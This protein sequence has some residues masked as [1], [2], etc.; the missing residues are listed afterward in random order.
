MLNQEQKTILGK[1]GYYISFLVRAL[2]PRSIPTFCEL[3]IASMI[4]TGCFV[5]QSWLQGGLQNFWGSYHKWLETGYWES[6]R[7]IARFMQVLSDHAGNATPVS[8]D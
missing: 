1:L 7:V 8:G 2:P 3:L 5:T 4:T 6:Y